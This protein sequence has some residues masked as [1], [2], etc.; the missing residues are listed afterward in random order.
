MDTAQALAVQ[1]LL[2]V[3]ETYQATDIHFSVGNPPMMR[4][5]GKLVA[6][7]E[8]PFVTPDFMND[9]VLSWLTEEEKQKLAEEK[10]LLIAKTFDNKKRFKISLFYQQG[11]VSAA[12]S[13][14]PDTIPSLEQMGISPIAQRIIEAQQGIV[15]IIGPHGARQKQTLTSALEHINTN[16]QKHI[17]TFEQPVEVLFADKNSVVDQREIGSD[18]A[19]L[20]RGL[21]HIVDEDI[22]CIAITEPLNDAEAVSQ[23]LQ[24]ASAGKTVFLIMDARTPA[25]ALEQLIHVFQAEDIPQVRM[26]IASTLV[27]IINQRYVQ[28]RAND[29]MLVHDVMIPDT[30]IRTILLQGE[31]PQLR[32]VIRQS[33]AQQGGISIDNQILEHV[34]Q[35]TITP[36]EA[37]KH[38]IDPS[39]LE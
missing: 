28:S 3:A 8:Q 14:I 32:N 35:G 25:A 10:D 5:D 16:Q 29:H 30:A 34:R 33:Q 26:Q 21:S 9:V 39:V 15:L 13:M 7:P 22:D 20:S 36:E 17:V 2:S 18:V 11:Y 6:V 4:I 23:L 1:K 12:L 38:I 31:L 37:R 19:S 24:V 27:G